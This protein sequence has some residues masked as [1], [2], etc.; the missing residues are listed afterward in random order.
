MD[1]FKSFL[2]FDM[3]VTPFIIKI[4]FW[5]GVASSVIYGLIVSFSGIGLMFSP[6]D[7]AFLG[8]LLFIGGFL[9]IAIGILFSRLYCELLII[10]FKMNET[11]SSIN[12]KIDKVD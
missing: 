5:V 8:F 10:F 6:F 1:K 11:L 4:L 3:M 7:S 12:K 2:N 9:V